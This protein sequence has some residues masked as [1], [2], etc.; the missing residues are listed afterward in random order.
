M[1]YVT[2]LNTQRA[3]ARLASR[4][5]IAFDI[6]R[7]DEKGYLKITPDSVIVAG[8]YIQE[9]NGTLVCPE[10]GHYCSGNP[11]EMV[12]I[13]RQLTNSNV[14]LL[15]DLRMQISDAYSVYRNRHAKIK[16]ADITV[17]D[18]RIIMRSTKSDFVLRLNMDNGYFSYLDGNQYTHLPPVNGK[19]IPTRVIESIKIT[20]TRLGMLEHPPMFN[21]VIM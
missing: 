17:E 1:F 7:L 11:R 12:A 16:T 2:D 20:L 6:K 8:E 3:I 14:V 4:L 13:F 15:A 9:E 18:E 10:I 19:R 5:D 21:E